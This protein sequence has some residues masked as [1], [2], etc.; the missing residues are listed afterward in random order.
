MLLNDG[1]RVRTKRT[2]NEVVD[3]L[4]TD[5][6]KMSPREKECFLQILEDFESK[7]KSSALDVGEKE[8][9]E[10][11][12][13]SMEQWMTDDNYFGRPCEG[14]WPSIRED[15][16]EIHSGDYNEVILSGAIGIGKSTLGEISLCRQLY[17]IGCLRNPQ[18]TYGLRSGSTIA[19]VNFSVS[20]KLAQK[21]V[22]DAI[23]ENI[24]MSPWF[25][26]NFNPERTKS[27]LR[28]PKNIWVTCSSSTPHSVLG[29][30]VIAAILDETNFMGELSKDQRSG[31]K[32]WEHIDNA[33]ILYTSIKRRIK[34]R[35][36][37]F[38]RLPGILL[39]ISSKRTVSDFTERR[40]L[41]AGDEKHVFVSE[42]ALWEA[43][44]D[45][46]DGSPRFK[47]IVGNESFGSRIVK[48]DED[49]IEAKE[50]EC[51]II[52]VP[53]DF[54][55]DFEKDLDQ[56]LRDLAGVATESVY[57]FIRRREKIEESIDTTK[58]HP[59]V[60]IQWVFGEPLEIQ[61]ERLVRKVDGIVKPLQSPNAVRHIHIDPSLTGDSA[62]F[63]V[64]HIE[65]YVDVRRRDVLNEMTVERAPF[66]VIDFLLKIIPPPGGEIVIA[67][68]RNLV[69]EFHEHGFSIGFVSMDSY[70]KADPIQ[71]LSSKGFKS[72]HVSMDL[73]VLPYQ[74]LKDCLY[75]NRL[76]M[77]RYDPVI[78]ELRE[79]EYSVR[80]KKVDHREDSSKDVS[81]SLA[82]VVYTLSNN[83]YAEMPISMYSQSF[84]EDA[85][86]GK[87]KDVMK[88]GSIGRADPLDML[89]SDDEDARDVGSQLIYPGDFL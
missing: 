7:G 40:I 29:L 45:R 80:K 38:G 26:K 76:R 5:F 50:K 21:V 42:R 77:Y 18:R 72:A 30:N 68:L 11:I 55:S 15:L 41:E 56:S 47:V 25:S 62:G 1:E 66:I 49:L 73:S 32:K 54:K 2:D 37:M 58:Q 61:W 3:I 82:G 27:E 23:S 75:D 16:L 39:L 88:R 52:D 69:Y 4:R 74:T 14:L 57:P 33:Q 31:Y 67:E 65:S 46:Y 85:I 59:C 34:S 81:D 19:L 36:E 83:S 71:I 12:P 60:N 44:P 43:K 51:R 9:Y 8:Q 13:V 35:F 64:G 28:F 10:E 6:E 22:F 84:N 53:I 70:I 63:A 20:E 87:V 24:K 86:K 48:S 17:E 78:T 89:M 79:L